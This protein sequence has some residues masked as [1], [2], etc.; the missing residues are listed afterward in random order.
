VVTSLRGI[1]PAARILFGGAVVVLG[2]ALVLTA[3]RG[4][5]AAAA[6]GMVAVAALALAS[7]ARGHV[8]AGLAASLGLFTGYVAWV[9]ADTLLD[10][11]V[12]LAREPFGDLRWGIWR[13]ALR[14]A[15]EAPILGVGLGTF[16]DAIIAYRPAGLTDRFYVDYAHND[17]LQLLAESGGLGAL[18]LGWAAVAWLTFVVGR[19]RDRQDVFV[20]GLVMGGLGAMAAVAFHSTVDF[21]LHLPANALLVVVVLALLPAVVTLRVHRAGLRVDLREWRWELGFRPRVAIGMA[22]L[23]LVAVTALALV[24]AAIADWRY[25]AANRLA[26][27]KRRAQGTVTM[28]DLVAAEGMLREAARLAPRNPRIQTEWAVAAAELGHRVW[29]LALAPDGS[30]LRAA[31]ARD[32]LVASQQFLGPAYGAYERVLRLQ[33][34]MSLNHERFGWF[35]NRL[36]AVRRTVA[37]EG[38]QNVVV[39]ELIQTLGSDASLLPRALQHLQAAVRLDPASPARRLSLV[40]FAVTHRAEMP[41]AREIILWEA[42]EA[43]RLDPVVLPDV[44]RFLTAQAVEPDLLWRAVPRDVATLVE[45]ARILENRG[46]V[47]TAATALEDATVVASAPSQKALVHLSRAR[48]LLR[49]GNGALAL[50]QARQALAF[51]PREPEAFAVLAEAYEASK[52]FGEAEAAIGSALALSGDG[53]AGKRKEYRDRLASLLTRRGDAA[54]VIALRRQ[55]VQ[56]APNDAGAHLELARAF[57]TGQ[58]LSEAIH[59]YE[60]ARG[61]GPDDWALQWSVAQ[62]FV[63]SGL[64]REATAAAERA[65]RLNP[66]SDDL[67]VELG[68]LYSRMGLPDRATEQYRQV[69]ERQPTHEA[70]IRGLRVVGGV[71]NPG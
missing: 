67:R 9:G 68:N 28:A 56:S 17:Y 62:A 31:T 53:D 52:F 13:A 23:G 54:G 15:A 3:S 27:E 36:D 39:P 35:L 64:L 49:R 48:F 69:L 24:P 71:Q 16:E 57:E 42:R 43:I 5:V 19:W 37:A 20:R 11:F 12:V 44:T 50:E 55:A 18:V 21:G 47:S 58:Q 61:L 26:G 6:A 32:R 33:P 7:R 14:V 30:R 66:A 60:T 70:A 22:V 38:L 45:L 25:Q 1:G 10:R 8:V 51:A 63:R 34:R 65:V 59:E 2:V 41:A 40:A 29:T 4:G 46:R